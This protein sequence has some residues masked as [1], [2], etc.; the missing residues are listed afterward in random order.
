MSTRTTGKLKGSHISPDDL[1]DRLNRTLAISNGKGK[2]KANAP[3][4]AMSTT[5]VSRMKAG[6]DGKRFENP[7]K[8]QQKCNDSTSVEEAQIC[9]VFNRA[10]ALLEQLSL[11]PGSRQGMLSVAIATWD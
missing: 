8:N 10:T 4:A 9:V 11:D 2:R 1:A 6:V 5:D 7:I 3:A